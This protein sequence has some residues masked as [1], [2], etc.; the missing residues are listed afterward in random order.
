MSE[1][2]YVASAR[3]VYDH[4]AE[5]YVAAVGTQVSPRFE[6]ALDR[7]VL[8]T[9]AEQISAQ[10]PGPVIDVGCGTGRATAYLA[11]LGL[12][13]RGV[14]ISS[15]MIEAARAAHPRLHFDVGSLTEL[16]VPDSSMCGAVYWYSIIATP[17]SELPAAWIELDRVLRH[18]GHVLVAFQ[19]GDNECVARP[20]AY[21]S[22]ATLTLYHHCVDDVAASLQVAG[23]R[24]QAEVRRQAELPHET[25]SQAFLLVR[26]PPI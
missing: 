2:E 13:V 18:D 19:C 16:A 1:P 14:D 3:E 4:S 5:Q 24:I 21:G 6:T 17:R 12:D 20:E 10:A 15:R 23:F 9:F 26:R 22:S 25:T 11:D 8:H 7:A